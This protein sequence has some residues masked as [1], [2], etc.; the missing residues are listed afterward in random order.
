VSAFFDANLSRCNINSCGTAH[1]QGKLSVS[2][3]VI[4]A[5]LLQNPGNIQSPFYIH[6]YIFVARVRHI[7]TLSAV[8]HLG[9]QSSTLKAIDNTNRLL[10]SIR[11]SEDR[12][13]HRQQASFLNNRSLGFPF[14]RCHASPIER[15]AIGHA[16]IPS[17]LVK[18]GRAKIEYIST[19]DVVT[20]GLINYY[21][22]QLLRGISHFQNSRVALG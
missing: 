8:N 20:D 6:L 19:E 21:R 2:S 18:L 14:P 9:R 3:S 11:D 13:T 12:H 10:A 15:P 7:G 4:K 5:S 22:A 16:F 17:T 1:I